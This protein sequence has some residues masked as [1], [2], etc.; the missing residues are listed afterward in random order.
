MTDDPSP[1]APEAW[2]CPECGW[3]NDATSTCERCGLARAWLEDPPLDLPPPPGWFERPA[4]WL[5]LL[6]AA[7]A[8]GGVVLWLRPSLAPFLALGDP[9]QAIQIALSAAAAVTAFNRAAME[10]LFHEIRL[11]LPP[12]AATDTPFD[13]ELVLVPYRRVPNVTIRID[14]VENTYRRTPG[15]GDR[16]AL[17]SERLARHRIQT[18]APLGGRRVHHVETTFVAPLPNME[19]HD[20]LAEIQASLLAPL[21]WLVPGLGQA[22]RN[23]REHGGVRVRASVGVGPYRRVLE[24]R[25]VIYMLGTEGLLAG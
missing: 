22:A 3:E 18:G 8:I 7:G 20:T 19:V 9:W 17:R 10:R 6:H 16:L 11:A 2:T 21:A 14:L 4:S 23:L 5:A 13:V 24:R 15:R 12:H 1:G 25:I